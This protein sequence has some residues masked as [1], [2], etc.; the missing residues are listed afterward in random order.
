MTDV[1]RSYEHAANE[2]Q[3]QL[4]F[5]F[6]F[7]QG[8]VSLLLP[9]VIALKQNLCHY[10]FKKIKAG[11]MAVHDLDLFRVIFGLEGRVE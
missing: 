10:V 5:F 3:Q 11:I 4:H 9:P 1:D 7:L 8:Y 2:A 6:F